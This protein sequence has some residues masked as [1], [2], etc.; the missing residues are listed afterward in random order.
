[1]LARRA[2]VLL[3][4]SAWRPPGILV[5]A[6]SVLVETHAGRAAEVDDDRR[7]CH[8]TARRPRRRRAVA[9]PAGA[10]RRSPRDALL[11]R[12]RAGAATF[13]D[14]IDAMLAVTPGAVGVA[15]QSAALRRE[16][17]T[18]SRPGPALRA[19]LADD[20]RAARPATAPDPPVRRRDRRPAVR[21]AQHGEVADHR[22]LPQ[23][24]HVVTRRCH[25]R[26]RRRRPPAGG[27]GTHLNHPLGMMR[28]RR[29]RRTMS[30]GPTKRSGGRRCCPPI[31]DLA[32]CS[33]DPATRASRARL[34]SGTERR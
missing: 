29:R 7:R 17:N 2:R 14:E 23:A 4:P 9:Q 10:H 28:L 5:L 31:G 15:G 34:R 6:T 20:G 12:D 3:G 11:R 25:R 24:R 26:R 33:D 18:A 30:R 1:M 27:L 22:H 13:L 21:V 19:G 32:T 16:L 8:R